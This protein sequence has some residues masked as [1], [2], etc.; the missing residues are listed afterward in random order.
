MLNGDVA[1]VKITALKGLFCCIRVLEVPFHDRIAPHHDLALRCAVHGHLFHI[2]V[3]HGDM[4]HHRKGDALTRFDCG[5]LRLLQPVPIVAAPDTFG[6]MAICYRQPVD[7]R[8]IKAQGFDFAQ[9]GGGRWG[10]RGKNLDHV[11][12]GA[13][14]AGIGIHDHVKN[15]GRPA[16]VGHT[17]VTD[18]V[19]DR[20]SGDIPAAHQRAPEHRHHPGVVPPVAVKQ[21]NDSHKDRVELHPP[22]D[23]RAHGHQICAAV[24]IDHTLGAACCA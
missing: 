19:I 22:A 1:G 4:F 18:G 24:M 20:R 6:D 12:K 15:N 17:F 3:H 10:A 13:A 8:D 5:L 23:H 2:R 14:V 16:E 21:G 9:R 7:L 11:I